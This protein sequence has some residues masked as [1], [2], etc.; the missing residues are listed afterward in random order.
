MG[1]KCCTSVQ[2]ETE[3][4]N[5]LTMEDDTVICAEQIKMDLVSAHQVLLLLKLLCAPC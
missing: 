4:F 1:L 3:N 2:L 5:V